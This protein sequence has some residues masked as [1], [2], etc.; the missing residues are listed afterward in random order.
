MTPSNRAII[1]LAIAPNAIYVVGLA[2]L[3][4]WRSMAGLDP[5]PDGTTF[6]V[7][8]LAGV[9]PLASVAIANFLRLRRGA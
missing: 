3:M 7:A 5:L 4:T 1:F 8:G 9:I 2:G 6:V